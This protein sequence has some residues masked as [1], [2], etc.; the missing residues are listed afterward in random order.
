VFDS[1]TS[2]YPLVYFRATLPCTTIPDDVPSWDAMLF[3]DLPVLM[4]IN[5]SLLSG[6][7]SRV[8]AANLCRSRL[9]PRVAAAQADIRGSGVTKAIQYVVDAHL[10]CAS[11]DRRSAADG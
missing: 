7:T 6:G 4:G 2:G 5:S 8:E 3:W 1:E 9:Q 11:G 10:F